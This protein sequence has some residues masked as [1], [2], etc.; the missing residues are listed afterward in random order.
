MLKRV[1][2]LLS[3][4]WAV[5]LLTL[6]VWDGSNMNAPGPYVVAFAPLMLGY[7][8]VYGVRFVVNGDTRPVWRRRYY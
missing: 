2:L 7:A 5:F 8:A 4:L 3:V 6:I 1:W